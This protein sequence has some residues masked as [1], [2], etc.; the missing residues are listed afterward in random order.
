MLKWVRV[1]LNNLSGLLGLDIK[2]HPKDHRLANG[3]RLTH[4]GGRIF[5]Y[6]ILTQIMDSLSCSPLNKLPEVPEYAEMQCHL[7]YNHFD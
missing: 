2:I 3:D 6:L 4:S 7:I 5:F 1:V